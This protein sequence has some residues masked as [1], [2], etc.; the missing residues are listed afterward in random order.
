M[1]VAPY[2]VS[3]GVVIDG[4]TNQPVKGGNGVL[5]DMAGGTVQAMYDLI[6]NPI[7]SIP[8]NDFGVFSPFGMDIPRGTLDFGS[9]LLPVKSNELDDALP[10]AEQARDT[11]TAAVA[12][13]TE[14]AAAAQAAQAAAQAAAGYAG[15]T[16]VVDADGIPYLVI[17]D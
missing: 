4:T 3:Q 16:V 5:R 6:G 7:A 15:G 8:V 13:A 11:A 17:G 12:A 10:V 14:A 1:A 2:T 9:V